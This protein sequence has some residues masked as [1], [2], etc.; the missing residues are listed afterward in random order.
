MKKIKKEN[1]LTSKD[2]EMYAKKDQ[3]GSAKNIGQQIIG[4]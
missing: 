3:P 1:V 4:W 2:P